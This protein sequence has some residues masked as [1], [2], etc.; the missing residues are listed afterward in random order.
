MRQV[1]RYLTQAFTGQSDIRR[2]LMAI[3]RTNGGISA[4][5]VN[6]IRGP[7]TPHTARIAAIR[8]WYSRPI[9]SEI[10]RRYG[11]REAEIAVISW[12]G[13][14]DDIRARDICVVSSRPKNTISRAI[15]QLVNKGYITRQIDPTDRREKIINLTKQGWKLY[16]QIATIWSHQ[17]SILTSKLNA[18]ELEKFDDILEKIVSALILNESD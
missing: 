5:Y 7:S 13:R 2:E 15:S 14:Q 3:S 12:L 1:R 16:E 8:N 18:D 4:K 17:E 11:L 6:M 9:Y 10:E